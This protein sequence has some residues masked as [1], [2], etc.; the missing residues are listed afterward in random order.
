MPEGSSS[1]DAKYCGGK[2]EYTAIEPKVGSVE[3]GVHRSQ[4]E[5]LKHVLSPKIYHGY[6][7]T[8]NGKG[9]ALK[10]LLCY[11]RVDLHVHVYRDDFWLAA[12]NGDV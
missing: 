1:D 11:V 3:S 4:R 8:C 7:C 10:G 5:F 9:A 6:R 12:S 2:C